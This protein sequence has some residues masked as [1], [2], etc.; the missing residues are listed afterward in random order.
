MNVKV[1]PVRC[2]VA[3]AA[4]TGPF[5]KPAGS[6]ITLADHRKG[7][8]RMAAQ[9]QVQVAAHQH[10]LVDRPMHLMASRAA[11][12]QRLMLPDKRAALVLMALKAHLIDVFKAR[13]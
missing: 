10:F 11:F 3:A 5:P 13:R 9:A 12:A 6:M 1:R 8:L 4:E 7:H 2:C